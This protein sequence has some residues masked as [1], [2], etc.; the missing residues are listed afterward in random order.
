MTDARTPDQI[1]AEILARY[2]IQ[3]LREQTD[4]D[5]ERASEMFYK[6][7]SPLSIT[8][9]GETNLIRWWRITS[10]G[11]EYEARRFKNWVWCSCRDFYFKGRMCKHLAFTAGVYCER[12]RQLAA[13]V[14]KLCYG[15][16]QTINHFLRTTHE[17]QETHTK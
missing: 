16:D 4:A 13:R 14:G 9:S 6:A 5:M 12:C 11:K 2:S 8:A 10:D 15:C 7:G 17:T 3:D 1:I